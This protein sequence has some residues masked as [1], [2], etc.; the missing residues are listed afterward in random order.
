MATSSTPPRV[1]SGEQTFP[2]L[3]LPVEIREMIYLEALVPISPTKY[4]QKKPEHLR[5]PDP[6]QRDIP[7]GGYLDF[8]PVLW[9]TNLSF[10]NFQFLSR[11]RSMQEGSAEG[12][13]VLAT[14]DDTLDPILLLNRQISAEAF[15]ILYKERY[16]KVSIQDQ[17]FDIGGVHMV[18]DF[19]ESFRP[20]EQFAC[21]S[22]VRNLKISFAI[23]EQYYP[24]YYDNLQRWSS[25]LQFS[26]ADMWQ[27]RSAYV[28]PA[29]YNLRLLVYG[30]LTR[31]A[32]LK[33]IVVET[34]CKC[35]VLRSMGMEVVHEVGYPQRLHCPRPRLVEY[36]LE[37]L[38]R[39]RISGRITLHSDCIYADKVR[40]NFDSMAAVIQGS[41]PPAQ[42]PES[43]AD[44]R[45]R[46]WLGLRERLSPM[47]DACCDKV[48]SSWAFT[49][50]AVMSS[51]WWC[52]QQQKDMFEMDP[53][54]G[55]GKRFAFPFYIKLGYEILRTW[56]RVRSDV[57]C[58]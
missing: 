52:A 31:C 14:G 43:D 39:L 15:P 36:L 42:N 4:F 2:L 45:V 9:D 29:S 47:I 19:F 58:A 44:R 38:R 48:P 35:S 21:L 33:T 55:M 56:S 37:P 20:L 32:P 57:E 28:V 16:F 5:H 26:E 53:V 30:L 41:V 13:E 27:F 7:L 40:T 1:P 46:V 10:D 12:N 17:G 25:A 8:W 51:A 23:E 22:E 11:N 54:L 34:S 50:K 3:R 6:N 24:R 49:P 18:P